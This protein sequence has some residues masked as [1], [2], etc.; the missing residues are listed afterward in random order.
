MHTLS[1]TPIHTHN[2]LFPWHTREENIEMLARRRSMGLCGLMV[3]KRWAE[4]GGISYWDLIGLSVV[5]NGSLLQSASQN[6]QTRKT[7]PC[8]GR[9]PQP[10]AFSFKQRKV[11]VALWSLHKFIIQYNHGHD[12]NSDYFWEDHNLA[13]CPKHNCKKAKNIQFWEQ[14]AH[15]GR[16]W[17]FTQKSNFWSLDLQQ[18]KHLIKAGVISEPPSR[19]SQPFVRPT[20]DC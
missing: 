15:W 8:Y 14:N 20:S 1:H 4:E 10:A 9:E 17:I 7:F 6:Q 11:Q 13:L 2:N 19:G 12:P 18:G 3:W 5:E 16:M